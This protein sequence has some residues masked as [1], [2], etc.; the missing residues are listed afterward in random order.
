MSLVIMFTLFIGAVSAEEI[1]SDDSLL[2]DSV[3]SD[4]SQINIAVNFESFMEIIDEI[5]G[6][7]VDVPESGLED[8]N[9]SIDSCYNYYFDKDSI[10]EKEYL[11]H[12]GT[13]RLNG[14][15]ALAFSRIRYT[16]SAFQREA[17]HRE[18]VESAYKEFAQKGIDTYKRCADIVL[19]NTKMN[20]SPMEMMNLAYTVLKINDSNIDQFQFPL[21]E[22][23]KGHII[24]KEKGW[25]LEWDRE[26]NLEAWHKFIFVEE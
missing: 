23:R 6:V 20:I 4:L 16:D 9:S 24:S 2:T 22:Y 10:D 5:S 8:I 19:N 17:R 15:Q 25:V 3:N 26:P 7:V 21:E 13:Q 18:V 11:T 14:Y 1:S 12:T